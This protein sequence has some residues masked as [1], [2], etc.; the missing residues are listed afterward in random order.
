MKDDQPVKRKAIRYRWSSADGKKIKYD[1]KY[2]KPISDVEEQEYINANSPQSM[3]SFDEQGD[4]L[5]F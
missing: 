3:G 1:P 5:P 2:N 4:A